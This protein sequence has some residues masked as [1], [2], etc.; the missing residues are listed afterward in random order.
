[1]RQSGGRAIGGGDVSTAEDHGDAEHRQ[2]AR[3]YRPTS[4]RSR[5]P[6]AAIRSG[7][8]MNVAAS[9]RRRA[10]ARE[11]CADR[12]TPI[13][14]TKRSNKMRKKMLAA[15]VAAA[16]CTATL[17]GAGGPAAADGGHPGPTPTLAEI[18]LSDGNQF[19][20]QP[21][22]LRHRHRGRAAIPRTRRRGVRPRRRVDRVPPQRLGVPSARRR[23]GGA[24]A[25]PGAGR[26]TYVARPNR[27]AS[28]D[29][30]FRGGSAI[31]R[32]AEP[33]TASPRKSDIVSPTTGCRGTLRGRC[34]RSAAGH[35]P[36]GLS[37]GLRLHFA[38]YRPRRS[39]AKS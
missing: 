6:A 2:L 30:P 19:R 28:S 24:E 14:A 39:A 9:E 29:V 37:D 17:A 3:R 33:C 22:R 21:V 1:M 27:R 38:G 11:R 13:R 10:N 8:P 31:G 15:V 36:R 23:S 12:H 5:R 18:F 35:Y 7:R 25:T 16:S 32:R 26:G 20:P 4:W 34:L